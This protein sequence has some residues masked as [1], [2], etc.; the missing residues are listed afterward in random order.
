VSLVP[1]DF[2]VPASHECAGYHLE[3]LGPEH[4]EPDYAAWTSSVEHIR[5]LADFAG[6]D[7]P[8]PSMSLEDNLG[9]LVRHRAD[10]TERRGFTYTVLDADRDV[11]GCLYI[12][13]DRRDGTDAR[14]KSWLRADHAGREDGFRG[15]INEWVISAW[16]FRT[17]LYGGEARTRPA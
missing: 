11:V 16:P 13:P 9:D 12:Y 5:S 4:N 14:I 15:S 10:F 2:P 7:W 17:W 1:P 8:D 3:P 6:G